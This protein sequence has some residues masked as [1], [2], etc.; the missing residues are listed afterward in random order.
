MQITSDA[1]QTSPWRYFLKGVL[2]WHMKHERKNTGLSNGPPRARPSLIIL[3]GLAVMGL[4]G[5]PAGILLAGSV[6]F[7]YRHYPDVAQGFYSGLTMIG[8]ALA[9]FGA[10]YWV[11]AGAWLAGRDDRLAEKRGASLRIFIV[12]YAACL[13]AV[14]VLIGL[15]FPSR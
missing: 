1:R 15:T 14:A 4:L 7:F 5:T 9:P 6:L 13:V 12:V 3:L 11:V 2:W 8:F 10:I